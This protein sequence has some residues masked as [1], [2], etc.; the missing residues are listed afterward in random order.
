M[1]RDHFCRFSSATKNEATKMRV[2]AFLLPLFLALAQCARDEAAPALVCSAGSRT[3]YAGVTAL[4]GNTAGFTMVVTDL[5]LVPHGSQPLCVRMVHMSDYHEV[6]NDGARGM[7]SDDSATFAFAQDLDTGHVIGAASQD[8]TAAPAYVP[9]PPAA[10]RTS[11]TVYCSIAV[12][13]CCAA[14]LSAAAR[15]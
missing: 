6:F 1:E 8:T 4:D 10:F 3:T 11:T 9:A 14:R 15:V 13:F 2:L 12:F 5:R 7:K